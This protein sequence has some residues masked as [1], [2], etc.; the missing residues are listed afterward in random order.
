MK[1]KYGNGLRSSQRNCKQYIQ[2]TAAKKILGFSRTTSDAV[3]RAELGMY[4]PIY[5]QRLE[6]VESRP[7]VTPLPGPWPYLVIYIYVA[8]CHPDV[9]DLSIAP[10][11]QQ[12]MCRLCPFRVTL[13]LIDQLQNVR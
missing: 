13:P 5:K 1:D 7:A 8:Q 10:R 6:E 11:K 12:N 9:I 3:L 4:P 2:M